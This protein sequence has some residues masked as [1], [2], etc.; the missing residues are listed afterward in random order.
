MKGIGFYNKD[1]ITIKSE[2]DLITE[3]IKRILLT[4]P[5]ERVGNL[6][7]GSRLREYLFDFDN[8]LLED[9][10]QVISSSI[11]KWEPRVIIQSVKVSKDPL[12]KEKMNV[13]IIVSMKET[14][15]GIF[16][17]IDLNNLGEDFKITDRKF[18]KHFEYHVENNLSTSSQGI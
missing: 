4:L 12:I 11:I 1:F 16:I 9:L 7:F 3:S 2:K 18:M 8:V 17:V 14:R 15:E 10:E 5:G 13:D 6:E